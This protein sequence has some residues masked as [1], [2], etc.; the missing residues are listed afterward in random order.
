M[1]GEFLI[2]PGHT[3]TLSH[4]ARPDA[5]IPAKTNLGRIL[6]TAPWHY[7]IMSLDIRLGEGH[8]NW[9][10]TIVIRGLP[11]QIESWE[12]FDELIERY[13][14]EALVV[15]QQGQAEEG[16]PSR[17]GGGIQLNPSDRA[18]LQQFVEAGS[19]GLLTTQIGP[20]LD[21]KG[22][23]IRPALS[24][25]SRKIGLVTDEGVA[26]ARVK[27]NDGRGYRLTDVHMTA[28]R[29]MLGL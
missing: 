3:P 20:A 10:K 15:A 4:S 24:R 25:W 11:I 18:L 21:A 12:E 6:L 9:P 13:G 16:R 23:G 26:F 5:A 2:P 7:G 8:M 28:A 19:R 29:A 1:E 22:K 27:R 14:G 17:R